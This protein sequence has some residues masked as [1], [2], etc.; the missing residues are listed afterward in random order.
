MASAIEFGCFWRKARSPAV[1]TNRDIVWR[2]EWRHL[3][4]VLGG[5]LEIYRYTVFHFDESVFHE[6]LGAVQIVAAEKSSS[7]AHTFL[8]VF[9]VSDVPPSFLAFDER[10]DLDLQ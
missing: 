4:D 10:V 8:Y 3:L 7:Q 5:C 6:L 9:I 2:W 1:V